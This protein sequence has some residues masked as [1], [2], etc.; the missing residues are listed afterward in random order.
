MIDRRSFA[1]GM[2][3]DSPT[4][5]CAHHQQTP[6]RRRAVKAPKPKGARKRAGLTAWRRSGTRRQARKA[7][8][9]MPIKVDDSKRVR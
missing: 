9:S 4:L 8:G 3:W 5:P 2:D 1:S 6:G 7:T